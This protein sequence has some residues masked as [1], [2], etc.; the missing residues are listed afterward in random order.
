MFT[1]SIF[2]L[3]PKHD[4]IRLPKGSTPIDFAYSLHSD[5]G[6]QCI[7]ASV[8]QRPVTIDTELKTG[9]FVEV[10]TNPKKKYASESWLDFVVTNRAK[11]MIRKSVKRRVHGL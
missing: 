1:D 10:Q 3:T 2:V 11:E 9:D 5:L 4:F 7:G 6:N 8:N